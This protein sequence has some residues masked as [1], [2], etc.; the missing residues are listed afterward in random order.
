[1]SEATAPF[2]VLR[3]RTVAD[4]GEELCARVAACEAEIAR[5]TA[6]VQGWAASG[7]PVDPVM[8]KTAADR[9]ADV[10]WDLHPL[11]GELRAAAGERSVAAAVT[12]RLAA[13]PPAPVLRLLTPDGPAAG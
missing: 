10:Q 2:P 12:R 1:M 5:F 9:V 7:A 3:E 13:P 6:A 11:R 8:L 4:I